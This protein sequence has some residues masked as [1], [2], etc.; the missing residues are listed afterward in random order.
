MDFNPPAQ[1]PVSIWERFNPRHLSLADKIAKATNQANDL[2]GL[3]ANA[4]MGYSP[5]DQEKMEMEGRLKELSGQFV[6]STKDLDDSAYQQATEQFMA[7]FGAPAPQRQTAQL[8]Q[9]NLLQSGFALLGAV[10]DPKNAAQIV[11]QPFEFQLGD[12]QR[13][14]G[15]NDQAYADQLRTRKEGIDAAE[16]RMTIEERKLGKAQMSQDRQSNMIRQQ[17]ADIESRLGKLDTKKQQEINHAFGQWGSANTPD[18][19]LISGR[20][21]Q[22]ILGDSGLAPTDQ[23]IESAVQGLQNENS[24]HANT[25]WEKALGSELNAFGEV[26]EAR[27]GQ[28]ETQRQAIAKR[29]GIDPNNLRVT[30]T[31]KTLKAQAQLLANE[32]FTFLKSKTKEDFKLKWANYQIAKQ[33]AATYAEAVANG[34][35]LGNVRNQISM[36]HLQMRGIE[37][38]TKD[39]VTASQKEFRSLVNDLKALSEQPPSPE[40]QKK[41][42]QKRA[43]LNQLT[44]PVAEEL[45]L[46]PGEILK[47]PFKVMDTILQAIDDE[48][49]NRKAEMEGVAPFMKGEIDPT[50]KGVQSTRPGKR[51]PRKKQ[52][53]P[54]KVPSGWKYS[55]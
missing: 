11:S 12:Q 31:A 39:M 47:D 10:L 3:F 16:T 21:L 23:E 49:T 37:S 8:Q 48:E 40:N 19:K 7:Q 53:A 50:T 33:R 22:R 55:G 15:Q 44:L 25:E 17:M 38:A 13:R 43:E 28:M 4:Q 20:R 18:E 34:F 54:G 1:S 6:E 52:P 45:G 14:Q 26:D 46:T 30:P 24:R 36:G 27:S 5:D 32:K 41:I 35:M 29:Y 9:P 42:A 2:S 51:P